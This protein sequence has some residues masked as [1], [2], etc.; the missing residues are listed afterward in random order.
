MFRQVPNVDNPPAKPT[1]IWDGECGF[2]KYWVTVWQNKTGESID[3]RPFQQ[4]S[5]NYTSIP[6]KE[7]KKASR[8]IETDGSVYSGPDSAFRSFL[9]FSKP[10]SLPHKWYHRYGFFKKCCNH[11][12][13]WIAKNR[14]F[15]FRLT[16]LFWGSDPLNRKPY[17]LIWIAG[18][19]G[20]IIII[21]TIIAYA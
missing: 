1:L 6:F 10:I 17:W 19:I 4:V 16:K 18:L 15:M 21:I 20:L 3:Y 5:D 7:F 14:P 2:C 11:T 8:L 12:Y 13:N 9:Y